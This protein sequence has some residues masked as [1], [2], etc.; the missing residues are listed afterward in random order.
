MNAILFFA[1]LSLI[2]CAVIGWL[3]AVVAARI[4]AQYR[5]GLELI[6]SRGCWHTTSRVLGSCYR[7]GLLPNAKYTADR[8]CDA[9]VAHVALTGV[10]PK[11]DHL[12]QVE[13]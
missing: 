2:V 4:A 12:R 10:E 1:I 7:D 11:A 13:V 8:C 3:L 5:R 6:A 9:C